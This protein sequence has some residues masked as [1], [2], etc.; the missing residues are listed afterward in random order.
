[1]RQRNSYDGPEVRPLGERCVVG[2]GSTG[3]PPKLPVLYNNL[4]QIVQTKT[5]V[6][7]MAEMNHDARIIRL[8]AEFPANSQYPWMGILLATTKET[9]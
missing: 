9:V 1:M 5:H 3:G 4:T 7:L 6:L 2:F 8:N